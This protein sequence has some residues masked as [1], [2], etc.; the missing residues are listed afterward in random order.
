MFRGQLLA[1]FIAP[2]ES[3]PVQSVDRSEAV[4]GQGLA[5]D[6]YSLATGTFSKGRAVNGPIVKPDQEVTLIESEVLAAVAA[7]Y[8]IELPPDQARRNLLTRGVPLNHLVSREFLVGAVRLR[9]LRLCEPCKH[10]EKLTQEGVRQALV[11]RGGLRAQIL[12]GGTLRVG[13]AIALCNADALCN[14]RPA[15]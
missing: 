9:G 4:A 12:A 5:G 13:D 3:A 1:I 6:R 8:G 14:A 15:K 10:L 7:D 11:H 2:R